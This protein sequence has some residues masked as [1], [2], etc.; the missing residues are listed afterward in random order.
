MKLTLDERYFYMSR[1]ARRFN[2]NAVE[3]INAMYDLLRVVP[4]DV[5][6]KYYCSLR[7]TVDNIKDETNK[8]T[9]GDFPTPQHSA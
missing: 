9:A 7:W 2:H 5:L 1:L 3:I 8:T 4:D 6:F